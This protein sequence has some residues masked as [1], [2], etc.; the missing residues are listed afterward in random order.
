MPDFFHASTNKQQNSP[1]ISVDTF[2]LMTKFFKIVV[3]NPVFLNP[4]AGEV[5][6]CIYEMFRYSNTTD[7]NERLLVRLDD[8]L[9]LVVK[10]LN[11]I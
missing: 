1:H 5:L 8:E 10:I 9:I 4:D 3:S 6:P 11:Y 2:F 7:L